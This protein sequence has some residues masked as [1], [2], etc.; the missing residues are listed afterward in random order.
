MQPSREPTLFELSTSSLIRIG[1]V[2]RAAARSRLPCRGPE[3]P[4]PTARSSGPA[5]RP[6]PPPRP[7]QSFRPPLVASL[8]QRISFFSAT[9]TPAHRARHYSADGVAS[10]VQHRPAESSTSPPKLPLQ[11]CAAC[12][13]RRPSP[14]CYPEFARAVMITTRC[15]I[16]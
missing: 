11:P 4:K 15:I 14:G 8:R 5:V 6:A 9:R 12:G 3:S 16:A 10:P 1:P 7:P 13:R 2:A